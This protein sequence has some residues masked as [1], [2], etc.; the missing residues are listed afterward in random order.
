[1]RNLL[2]WIL[3]VSLIKRQLHKHLSA[4]RQQQKTLKER[5]VQCQQQ[6]QQSDGN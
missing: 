1:M 2:Y 5:Y 6:R 4:Q 3:D